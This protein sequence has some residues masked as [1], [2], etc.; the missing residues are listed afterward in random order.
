[1]W[2]LFSGR[3]GEAGTSA[4][5]FKFKG[6]IYLPKDKDSSVSLDQALEIAIEVG[7]EEVIEGLDEDGL[8]SFQVYS[9]DY[10]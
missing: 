6:V 2:L 4:H 9:G 5:S 3:I 10:H 1:M 8:E 7:A